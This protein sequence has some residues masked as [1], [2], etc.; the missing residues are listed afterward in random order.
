MKKCSKRASQKD[1][2]TCLKPFF[3]NKGHAEN[4]IILKESNDIMPEPVQVANTLNDYFV[5]I[6]DDISGTGLCINE[7][8]I[9]N[10]ITH[11]NEHSSIQSI[12]STQ[13]HNEAKFMLSPVIYKCVSKKLKCIRSEKAT[14]YDWLT[15]KSVK[16]CDPASYSIN[17]QFF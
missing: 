7:C 4:A 16:M 1:F 5:H 3:T 9:E 8:T 17:K 11:H 12:L 15:P 6:A 2:W 13:C 14:G 10:V